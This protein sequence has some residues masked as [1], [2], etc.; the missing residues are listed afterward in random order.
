MG[1]SDIENCAQG[2]TSLLMKVTEAIH[3]VE[4]GKRYVRKK[5]GY[6]TYRGST[7]NKIIIL[8]YE[9]IYGAKRKEALNLVVPLIYF[10]CSAIHIDVPLSGSVCGNQAILFLHFL[11]SQ[12]ENAQ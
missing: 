8:M 1:T 9:V 12:K 11:F 5:K 10:W 4:C 3:F 6:D 2:A 7:G